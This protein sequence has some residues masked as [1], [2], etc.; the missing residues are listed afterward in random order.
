MKLEVT[1]KNTENAIILTAKICD[2]ITE[3]DHL[4]LDVESYVKQ[5]IELGY[6]NIPDDKKSQLF[7]A[8]NAYASITKNMLSSIKDDVLLNRSIPGFKV[9]TKNTM[10]ISNVDAMIEWLR[11]KY[12]AKDKD[13]NKMITMKVTAIDDFVFDKELPSRPTMK[14]SSDARTIWTAECSKHT[15]SSQ[16]LSVSAL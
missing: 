12:G 6:S 4:R 1:N 3:L 2:I 14:K 7:K 11:N 15:A 9:T 10:S 13:I 5:L 8:L 16:T